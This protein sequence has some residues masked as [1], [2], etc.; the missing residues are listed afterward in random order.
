MV[1]SEHIYKMR[2]PSIRVKLTITSKDDDRF[3]EPRTFNSIPD[4]SSATGLTDRGIRA[5]YH[6]KQELIQKRSGEVYT[7]KWEELDSIRV[8]PPRPVSRKCAKCSNPEDKSS[9]F[10]MY[11]GNNY[12]RL[13]HFISLYR[14]WKVTGISINAL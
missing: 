14:A 2:I 5:A 11:P 6:S 1:I 7:L 8:K 13:L 10:F 3:L 12:D 9:F 4:A